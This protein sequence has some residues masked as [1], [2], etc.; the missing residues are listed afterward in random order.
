M[1]GIFEKLG[2]GYGGFPKIVHVDGTAQ[3]EGKIETDAEGLEE[4]IA[5]VS[6]LSDSAE[7]ICFLGINCNLACR[8][9]CG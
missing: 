1:D 6:A 5:G 7:L 3:A 4:E 2:P 8:Q 9:R